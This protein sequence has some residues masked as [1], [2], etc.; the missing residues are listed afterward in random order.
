MTQK[1]I[2][3]LIIIYLF[4]LT[5][6]YI[7]QRE[8]IEKMTNS[9]NIDY[10]AIKSLGVI[11]KGLQV[12]GFNVPG[13]LLVNGKKVLKEGDNIR[14]KNKKARVWALVAN[15]GAHSNQAPIEGWIDQHGDQSVW[16]LTHA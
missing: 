14:L 3:I 9:N 11:A 13:N 8:C 4:W 15:G 10:E 2:N 1:I 6:K 12:N 5:F 7:K 16:S